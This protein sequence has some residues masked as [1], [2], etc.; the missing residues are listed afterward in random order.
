GYS[1]KSD[2]FNPDEDCCDP[3]NLWAGNNV[4]PNLLF[5]DLKKLE[6][7]SGFKIELYQHSEFLLFPVSGGVTSKVF[8]PDF[9]L[10]L[11]KAIDKFDDLMIFFAK[12]L[13]ALQMRAV[14][15]KES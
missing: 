9:P 12:D 11:L 14:L 4:I 10:W 3:N 5:N 1:Y 15:R 6:A 7:A 13:V 8:M 2:I